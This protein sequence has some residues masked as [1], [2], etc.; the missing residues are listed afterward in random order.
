ML[1]KF[2]IVVLI[3]LLCILLVV[4]Y[5]RQK[6]GVFSSYNSYAPRTEI[7]TADNEKFLLLIK[8]KD[9]EKIK[10]KVKKNPKLVFARNKYGQRAVHYAATYCATDIVKFL[11]ENGADLKEKD[12]NGRVP[13]HWA[14]LNGCVDTME[15]LY[16]KGVDIDMRDYQNYTPLI[17]AAMH[18]RTEAVKW[19]VERGVQ[20]DLQNE[21]GQ[22]ALWLA[23]YNIAGFPEVTQILIDAGADINIKNNEGKSPLQVS[24]MAGREEIRKQLI[25]AGAEEEHR[26]QESAPINFDPFYPVLEQEKEEPEEDF[27]EVVCAAVKNS[28]VPALKELLEKGASPDT[29]CPRKKIDINEGDLLF[30]IAVANRNFEVLQLLFDYNVNPDEVLDFGWSAIETPIINKDYELLDFLIKN[31]TSPN[32]YEGHNGTPNMCGRTDKE[33]IRYLIG[34]GASL[35][36][37]GYY[38]CNMLCTEEF[39]FEFKKYLIA[40][41]ATPSLNCASNLEEAKYMLEKGANVNESSGYVI[42]P[43]STAIKQNDLEFVKL[44]VDNGANIHDMDYGTM[45]TPLQNALQ[46]GNPEIINYLISKG[47]KPTL[48]GISTLKEAKQM[49]ALGANAKEYEDE[50]SSFER[51]TQTPLSSALQSRVSEEERYEL[52]KLLLQNG[53]NPNKGLID[54]ET[55]PLA[56]A[57]KLHDY[58]LVKLLIDN[59]ADVNL[60][61]GNFPAPILTAVNWYFKDKPDSYKIIELLLEKG[62]DTKNLSVPGYIDRTEFFKQILEENK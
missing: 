14:A 25:A 50:N 15:L 23:T 29:I 58:E 13:F 8:D 24:A 18:G 51:I 28:D 44:L 36:A 20:L 22:T 19:L 56:Q 33:M 12:N 16:P 34:K 55:T 47:V 39:D 40:N 10:K 3:T 45:K 30:E 4:L 11:I 38:T 9:L 1:K 61:N 42:T 6:D 7:K 27:T 62:A 52:V 32:S 49:L 46:N 53:S 48:V 59:G 5:Y 60:K 31:G 43:L 2:K 57:I 37:G 41:G 26:K 54:A 35:A 17:Y 21:K